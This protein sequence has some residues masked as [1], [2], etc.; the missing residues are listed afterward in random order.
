MVILCT[1]PITPRQA[2]L[3]KSEISHSTFIGRTVGETSEN[4]IIVT[5]HPVCEMDRPM[6][7]GGP[8]L[9]CVSTYWGRGKVFME[10]IYWASAAVYLVKKTD[11]SFGILC[12]WKLYL[13][14]L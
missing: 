2:L 6:A 7:A 8:K 11:W 14:V 12:A 5:G 3:I 10:V 1:V 4:V 9:V 13:H